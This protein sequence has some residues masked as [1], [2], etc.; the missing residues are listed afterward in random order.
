MFRLLA[1]WTIRGTQVGVRWDHARIAEYKKKARFTVNHLLAKI[2][3]LRRES[4][5]EYLSI[6][7]EEESLI[8]EE[9]KRR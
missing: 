4:G 3:G 6:K 2:R 9:G 1:S 5:E 8:G 7:E